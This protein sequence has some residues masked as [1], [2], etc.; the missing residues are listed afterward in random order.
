MVATS[1]LSPLVRMRAV[2]TAQTIAEYFRDMSKDVLFMMD[3]ITRFAM[4]SREVGL[5][6]GEPPTTKGY[7][8]SVFSQLPRLLERAGTSDKGTITGIYTVLVEGDDFTEPIADAVRSIVDGHIVLTRELA[9]QGHYPAIDVLKSISRLRSQIID[10]ELYKL[11]N[12]LLSTLA[13]YQRVEDMINIGAY[14]KGSNKDIDYAIEKIDKI[15]DF[16][17]QDVEEKSSLED[18]FSRLKLI[19][20]D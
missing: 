12:K 17:V 20:Q 18:S 14:S 5:S 10:K 9:D 15:N 11:G 7:T 4:A 8:P 19:V 1:D 16:L 2:Y 3:S 13:T 6:V